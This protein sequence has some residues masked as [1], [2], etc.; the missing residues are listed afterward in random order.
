MLM[1]SH[2]GNYTWRRDQNADDLEPFIEPAHSRCMAALTT[3]VDADEK[4]RD[5]GVNDL[6]SAAINS[7]SVDQLIATQSADA[8]ATAKASLQTGLGEAR[9]LRLP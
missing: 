6:T 9:V 8:L 5:A 4:A 2:L 3:C 7:I 1:V